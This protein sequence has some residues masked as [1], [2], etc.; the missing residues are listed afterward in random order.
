MYNFGLYMK[1]CFSYNKVFLAMI[2]ILVAHLSY[3]AFTGK[4]DD[5][6][7]K[8][9]LKNLNSLSRTYSLSSLRTNTF[10]YKGSQDVYQQNNGTQ[11]QVQSMIRMERGNTTYVYPYKYIVKVPRFKTPTAPVL[12]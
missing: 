12:R 3:G 9:S 11:V 2:L 7:N 1:K 10:L 4:S 6:K 8:F 5:H